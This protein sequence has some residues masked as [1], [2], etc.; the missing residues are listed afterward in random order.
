MAKLISTRP[1]QHHSIG[2][3]T[4]M[5][6]GFASYIVTYQIAEKMIYKRYPLMTVHVR[7]FDT[8]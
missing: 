8:N 2:M 1:L 3:V 6:I 4:V 5:L 7:E